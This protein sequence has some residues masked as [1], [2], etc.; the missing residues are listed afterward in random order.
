MTE[1]PTLQRRPA[2]AD[3]PRLREARRDRNREGKAP[4][5]P[6]SIAGWRLR[7]C[8]ARCLEHPT[9]VLALALRRGADLARPSGPPGEARL[10]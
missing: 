8:Y 1:A 10:R 3:A 4:R 6:S 7:Q 2:A 5:S 9:G